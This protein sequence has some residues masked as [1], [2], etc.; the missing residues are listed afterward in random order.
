MKTVLHCNH[1]R[2]AIRLRECGSL[3]VEEAAQVEA[4]LASCAGCR[5][6]AGEVQAATAGLRW[7]SSRD[8]EPRLGFRARWT[9]AVEEAARPGSLR[10]SAAAVVS[11]GRGLLFRNLRPALGVASLWILTLL[12]RLSTPE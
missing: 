12:F 5:L 9:Q 4:H 8:V 2:E 6:Y 1:H 10:E 11:W 7:L 3:G